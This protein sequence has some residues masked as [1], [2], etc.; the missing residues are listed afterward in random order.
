MEW[1]PSLGEFSRFSLDEVS[2]CFF[3]DSEG[4]IE[5]W[6]PPRLTFT[7]PFIDGADPDLINEFSNRLISVSQYFPEIKGEIKIG[8]TTSYKGLAMTE[9]DGNVMMKKIS[10]PPLKKS[11][12]PS[13]YVMGHEMMH[14][15]QAKQSSIPGT[16]RATDVHTLARLP[17]VFIDHAPIYLRVPKEIRRN[18]SHSRINPIVSELAHDLAIEAVITRRTNPRYIRW[19][20]SNFDERVD[21][22][23]SLS[24]FF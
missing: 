18:W 6:S 9:S 11:G 2:Q 15:V 24:R 22:N 14:I 21:R 3:T 19:W 7:K 12:L 1:E 10:F 23:S 5:L 13:R 17:P 16:E 20:E 4:M 8:M